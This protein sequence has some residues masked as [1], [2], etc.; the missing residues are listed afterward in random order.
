MQMVFCREMFV[1]LPVNIPFLLAGHLQDYQ[2]SLSPFTNFAL[3][4]GRHPNLML[5]TSRAERYIRARTAP[6][7]AT[8]E[9]RNILKFGIDRLESTPIYRPQIQVT[10]KTVEVGLYV[11]QLI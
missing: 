3:S 7:R 8:Y 1:R 4:F 2:Q 5:F 9:E 10:L 11:V 6:E